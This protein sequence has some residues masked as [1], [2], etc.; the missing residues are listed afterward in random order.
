M[1]GG[2]GVLVGASGEG[3]IAV[4]AAGRKGVQVG[5]PRLETR[6]GLGVPVG[7]ETGKL[8]LLTLIRSKISVLTTNQYL[9]TLSKVSM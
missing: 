6:S 1:G 7:V 3:V 9:K 5:E 4:G 2:G 8:Q